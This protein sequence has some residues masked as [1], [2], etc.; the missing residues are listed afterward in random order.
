MPPPKAPA[1]PVWEKVP[2]VSKIDPQLAVFGVQVILLILLRLW[3][4]PTR[5]CAN[6]LNLPELELSLTYTP[7]RKL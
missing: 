1:S 3:A 7:P 5:A 4:A 2:P 6:G